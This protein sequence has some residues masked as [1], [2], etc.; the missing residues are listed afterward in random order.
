[1]SEASGGIGKMKRDHGGRMEE[2][3]EGEERRLELKVDWI[4]DVESEDTFDTCVERTRLT[5]GRV[6]EREAGVGRVSRM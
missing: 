2:E 5:A 3:G 6:V 1:M 4:V